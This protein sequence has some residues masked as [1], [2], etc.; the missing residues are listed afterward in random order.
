MDQFA[1]FVDAGY[2]SA[3]AAEL[4]TGSPKR[5]RI[6]FD[7]PL[8]VN[9]LNSLG[10]QLATPDSRLLRIYWYDG[11]KYAWPTS[12][13]NALSDLP[14]V[15]VRLGHLRGGQQK[16]VDTLLVLDFIRLAERRAI[17]D[18]ILI[19]GDEDLREGVFYVQERGVRVHLVTCEQSRHSYTLAQEADTT[20]SL[21]A[22]FFQP[23]TKAR[24]QPAK[25]AAAGAPAAGAS[26]TTQPR[27][28][29]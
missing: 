12:W 18:A 27:K 26:T 23:F 14:N 25:A 19:G 4:I 21:D 22:S 15:K 13:H 5:H 10:N 6:K 17:S 8:L 20:R 1:I 7:F 9:A 16:G 24:S 11:A 29:S 2:F 3:A 28:S